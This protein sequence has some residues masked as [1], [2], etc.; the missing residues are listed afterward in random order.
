MGKKNYA[1]KIY[2]VFNPKEICDLN[3]DFSLENKKLIINIHLGIRNL[4]LKN[5]NPFEFFE[6]NIEF[7]KSCVIIGDEISNGVIPI[8]K[9]ERKW[10]DETGI[11]YQFLASHADLVDRVWAGLAIRLKGEP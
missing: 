10:R 2:G 7:L 9:F 4:L 3:T 5:Q 11:I 1:E 6:S 8:E